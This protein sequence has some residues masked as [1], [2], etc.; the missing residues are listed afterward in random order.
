M[1]R[2]ILPGGTT[3]RESSTPGSNV[4]ASVNRPSSR[5]NVEKGGH[6]PSS[7]KRESISKQLVS[8]SRKWLV[9]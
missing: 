6:L 5:T 9:E 2:N 1:V 7:P 8:S 4:N 3:L